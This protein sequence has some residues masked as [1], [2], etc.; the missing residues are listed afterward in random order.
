MA[1]GG[2]W[3]LCTLRNVQ[4]ERRKE[5]RQLRLGAVEGP[6]HPPYR[7]F[8]G[9]ARATL[10]NKHSPHREA[11]VEFLKYEAGQG[12]NDLINRQADA[13]APMKRYCYTPEYLRNPEFPEEDYNAVWRDVMDYAGPDQISPF[14]NGQAA[15]RIMEKQLDLVKNDQKPVPDA[16]RTAAREVN[17]EIQKTLQRDPSLRARYAEL[18]QG[19]KQ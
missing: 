13:L 4:Q 17:E 2:R 16:M 14:I 10:V 9:Y 6:H 5:G 8:R 3:W 15:S 19:R 1:I 12:Y 18:T 11:A 7:V